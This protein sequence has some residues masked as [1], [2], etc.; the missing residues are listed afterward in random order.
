M[1]L[2]AILGEYDTDR[3]ANQQTDGHEVSLESC[4]FTNRYVIRPLKI[5]INLTYL[6]CI[7]ISFVFWIC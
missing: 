7:I 2:S 1:Q 3:R 4:T 6:Y 5:L